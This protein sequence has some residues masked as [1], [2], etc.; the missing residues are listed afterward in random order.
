MQLVRLAEPDRHRQHGLHV[1][2]LLSAAQER[3][4][5]IDV[6]GHHLAS[7]LVSDC[8]ISLQRVE[9]DLVRTPHALHSF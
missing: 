9:I 7:G 8:A 6:D 1:D 2:E 3:H 5:L 4:K